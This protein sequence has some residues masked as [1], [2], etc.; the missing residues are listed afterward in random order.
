MSNATLSEPI[1]ALTVRRLDVDF[2][3]LIRRHWNGDDAFL[4]AFFNA[5]SFSFPEGEQFF[6]ESVRH[7][8]QHLDENSTHKAFKETVRGF[9]GQ[10]ASH[11]HIHK[12]YNTQLET[13]G[14]KNHWGPRIAKRKTRIRRIL[15]KSPR[16]HL[17]ELAITAAYEHFTSIL[18]NLTLE[19]QGTAAD[20]LAHADLPLQ[21]LW[22]W[23]AAE[24]CEHKTVAFDL[25]R[26]LGGSN[27]MRIGFFALITL[28]FSTDVM[29]QTINNLWHDR[30]LHKPSTWW[31]A[32]KFSLGRH[33]WV[34]RCIPSFMAYL[35]KDFH[36]NQIGNDNLMRDWLQANRSQWHAVIP[37]QPQA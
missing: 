7:A 26:Q 21:T 31:S 5:L 23:H 29:R 33:G 11:R 4:T 30:T 16:H 1:S 27:R 2:S 14:L 36:P 10:E 8:A 17:Y 34:W 18:G 13:L 3:T 19:S 15:A 22:R 20:W 9:I 28:H 24:E 6:I 25:Y 32:C 35:R 12:Q 37:H